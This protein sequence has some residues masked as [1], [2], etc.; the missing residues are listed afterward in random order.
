VLAAVGLVNINTTVLNDHGFPIDR[1][2]VERLEYDR[3]NSMGSWHQLNARQLA[4]LSGEFG[5]QL[6]STNNVNFAERCPIGGSFGLH[7]VREYRGQLVT[8]IYMPELSPK[9]LVHFNYA[10]LKGWIKPMKKGSFAVI[11]DQ[12]IEIPGDDYADESIEWL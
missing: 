8:V 9:E 1:L 10:G 4:S 12:N 7:M 3:E 6:T 5:V 11:G 2:L